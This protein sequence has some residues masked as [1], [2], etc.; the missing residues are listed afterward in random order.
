LRVSRVLVIGV[1]NEIRGDDA[2]GLHV[3]RVLKRRLPHQCNVVE[4]SGDGVHLME[5]WKSSQATILVD[6]V[7]SGTEPGQVHKYEAHQSPLPATLFQNSTHAFGVP[8]AIELARA[9]NQL[10]QTLIVYGIEGAC[11]DEGA[12]ISP[13]VERAGRK[14]AASIALAISAS[15]FD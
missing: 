12:G 4:N 6:A 13:L 3:C 2:V 9:M 5:L 11:F 10:P 8:Q 1:G 7:R 14:V 15:N